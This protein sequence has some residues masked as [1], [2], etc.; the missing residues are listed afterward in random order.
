M[1]PC[2]TFSRLNKGEAGRGG[3]CAFLPVKRFAWCFGKEVLN[4]LPMMPMQRYLAEKVA[5]NFSV[6]SEVVTKFG[7]Q[8]TGIPSETV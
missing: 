2:W 8:Q 6:I 7:R 1:G 3:K 5:V 4:I